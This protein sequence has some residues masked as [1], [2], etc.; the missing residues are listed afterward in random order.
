MN[1]RALTALTAVVLLGCA[2]A[3]WWQVERAL[4]GNIPS[5]CYAVLWPFYGGYVLYVRG[6]LSRATPTPEPPPP[7]ADEDDPALVA[8]NRFLAARKADVRRRTG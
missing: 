8:Y 1:R 6:R 5:Y 4:A 3:T 2:V 7:R